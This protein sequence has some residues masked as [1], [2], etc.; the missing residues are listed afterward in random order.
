MNTGNFHL[1]I[2]HRGSAKTHR[3]IEDIK[4]NLSINTEFC[5]GY[6]APSKRSFNR[7]IE[8]LKAD[9]FDFTSVVFIDSPNKVR[10]FPNIKFYFDE[11]EF[12]DWLTPK[13]VKK[14]V[15]PN[16]FFLSSSGK[17]RKIEEFKKEND[18]FAALLSLNNYFYT[19]RVCFDSELIDSKIVGETRQYC[20]KAVFEK[21]YLSKFLE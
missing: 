11:F 16:C 7:L 4:H 2:S 21:E 12:I 18:V 3:I 14:F 15:N 13:N 8:K 5:A 17:I 20:E 10:Y 6:A 19:S 9:G 1:E